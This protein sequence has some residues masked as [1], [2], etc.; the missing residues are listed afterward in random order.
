MHL[1]VFLAEVGDK[2][3][4]LFVVWIVALVLSL[5]FFAFARWRLWIAVIAVA[6]AA[7]AWAFALVSELRG[8]QVGPAILQELGRAYV[9]QSYVAVFIPFIFL[10]VGIA[11]WR[12]RE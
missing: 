9:I 10:V 2:E 8:P 1:S 12:R 7:A 11:P 5:S 6:I 4:T 3:P